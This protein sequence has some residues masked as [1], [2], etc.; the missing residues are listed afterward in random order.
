MVVDAVKE[1]IVAIG[2]KLG[3]RATTGG[4]ARS[5]FLS[6]GF[7]KFPYFFRSCLQLGDGLGGNVRFAAHLALF[8]DKVSPVL[9]C[10]AFQCYA[11]LDY[12]LDM[13]FR[14]QAYKKISLGISD[15]VFSILHHTLEAAPVEHPCQHDEPTNHLDLLSREWIE[16]AVEGFTGTLLFVS[17]DR[18]FVSRFATRVIYLENGTY[19]DFQGTYDEFLAYREANPPA[20]EKK[21]S[22]KIEKTRPRGGGTKN[23]AR[24]VTVLEREIAALE[25]Q[26]ASLDEEMNASAS[27]PDKLCELI[28]QREE[29]D[30]SLTEKMEEWEAASAAL[31]QA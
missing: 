11:A 27:D 31:E 1:I 8:L 4:S 16:E 23:L 9:F 19:T 3:Q 21:P 7:Y 30:A 26:L 6:C 29:A 17:H 28:A 2:Q 5:T 24:R 22:P 15:K 20:A 14:S 12:P 25:A 18:Y 10:S 13:V